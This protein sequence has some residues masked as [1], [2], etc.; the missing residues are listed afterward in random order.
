MLPPCVFVFDLDDTLYLERDYALS[1]FAAVGDWARAELRIADF[2]ERAGRLF[3]SGQRTRIFD[4]VLTQVGLAPDLE[5][6]GKMVEVFRNHRPA[7]S[8]LPDVE[9]FLGRCN[10]ATRLGLIT[11]GYE[12]AQR[13]KVEALDLAGRGFDPIVITDVWGREFWKPHARPYRTVAER[14][15]DARSQFVYIADNPAKDFI[16]PKAMGWV[17]IQ[18][19]REGGIHSP[20]PP[21]PAHAAHARIRTL[22]ELDEAVAR[23]LPLVGL[24]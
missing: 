22:D 21:S 3:A 13:N 1:G 18:A 24:T 5:R 4:A 15:A 11:D 6:V 7:L 12:A 20:E 10:A 19:E 17:T 8:L 2:S 16:T 14:H 9:R 23:S